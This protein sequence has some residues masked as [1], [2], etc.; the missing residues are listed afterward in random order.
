MNTAVTGPAT[1]PAA[2]E[3]RAP[4]S[5]PWACSPHSTA[6]PGPGRR[7]SVSWAG[8]GASSTLCCATFELLHRPG[9]RRS[10]PATRCRFLH[11]RAPSQRRVPA[12]AAHPVLVAWGGGGRQL[13]DSRG[14]P[15]G[16]SSSGSGWAARTATSVVL[17]GGPARPRRTDGRCPHHRRQLLAGARSPF[18]VAFFDPR[19]AHPPRP[20]RAD[21]DPHRLP[22]C[23]AANQAVPSGSATGGSASELPPVLFFSPPPLRLSRRRRVLGRAALPARPGTRCRWVAGC[24]LQGGGPAPA[25]AP[26]CSLLPDPFERFER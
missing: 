2:A 17:R 20:A 26:A 14:S 19:S 16:G 7:G 4:A 11:P 10:L 13:S 6:R 8:R 9:V 22:L 5:P 12:A 25:L 24:G 15:P 23:V 1:G 18:H 3:N 21:P